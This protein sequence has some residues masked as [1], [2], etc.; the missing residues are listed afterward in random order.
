SESLARS[1]EGLQGQSRQGRRRDLRLLHLEGLYDVAGYVPQGD[2]LC[3]RRARLPGKP[4]ALHAGAGRDPAEGK[5]DR[6]DPGLGQG[7]P[8]RLHGEGEGGGV[9]PSLVVAGLDP[10][11]PTRNARRP[12]KRDGRDKPGDDDITTR[13]SK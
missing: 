1:R 13:I 11:T 4:Q 10:A 5:E 12:P 7:A 9:T 6:R 3:R 2:E 8:P